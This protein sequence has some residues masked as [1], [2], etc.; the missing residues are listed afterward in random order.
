[1]TAFVC[2][3]T[4]ATLCR[5]FVRVD[6]NDKFL[7]STEAI[8]AP[9]V[10]L[11]LA[12][13]S[14]HLDRI[15]TFQILRRHTW[16]LVFNS[17]VCTQHRQVC[18]APGS[19]VF[20]KFIIFLLSFILHKPSR[21]CQWLV[22]LQA[23]NHNIPST[24]SYLMWRVTML[25]GCHSVTLLLYVCNNWSYTTP[26]QQFCDQHRHRCWWLQWWQR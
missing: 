25:L 19:V 26:L 15:C 2:R 12:I 1:M 21:D 5:Q 20:H 11:M 24:V 6:E 17:S 8:L 23:R 14:P 18:N 16:H 4:F 9:F 13:T 22:T 10:I 3:F 7:T